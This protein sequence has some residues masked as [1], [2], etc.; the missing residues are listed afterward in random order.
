MNP[1][2]RDD[3][4][5]VGR[6]KELAMLVDQ[7][8]RGRH[9]LLVGERGIGKTRLMKE[10]KALME[11]GERRTENGEWRTE[12]GERESAGKLIYVWHGAPMG[13]MLKEI[14]LRL[15]QRKEL[16]MEGIGDIDVS[17]WSAVR[18]KLTGLGTLG[19]QNM[20]IQSLRSAPARY[21]LFF[22]SLDRITVAHQQFLEK[23]LSLAILCAG[24]TSLKRGFGKIWSSFSRMVLRPLSDEDAARLVHHL[25]DAYSI[26]LIDRRMYVRQVLKAAN[27]NPFH[28]R[29]MVWHGSLERRL[30]ER[31]IR[32]LQRVEQGELLNLGPAYIFL[33]SAFTLF[34]IFSMGTARDEFYV[35]F[36]AL[37]F[38]VYLTFRVFRN[39]FLFRPQRF[40]E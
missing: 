4:T 34:K 26:H 23:L 17:D 5:L 6:E 9:V 16:R 25:L 24:V 10:A 30:G 18:K 8:R 21:V 36:S 39:F 22:D 19:V 11:N 7:L 15:H 38:L 12:N 29:N 40:R 33:A 28:L 31:E 37:G 35:Y 1:D 14:C 32:D 3:P 2:L 20:V 27:G 13:D